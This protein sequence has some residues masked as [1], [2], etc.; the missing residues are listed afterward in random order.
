MLA[1]NTPLSGLSIVVT[2]GVTDFTFNTAL[3]NLIAGT[4]T[5]HG[6]MAHIA[7]VLA[8]YIFDRCAATA[9]IT[10][11]PVLL[12]IDLSLGTPQ[13]NNVQPG[14][15]LTLPILHIGALGG[16]A[17]GVG[18]V[19][20]KSFQLN[21]STNGWGSLWAF[22]DVGE[23]RLCNA[24][25]GEV[26]A[27]VLN[28]TCRFQP[29]Y[30]ASF[31]CSFVDSGNY[32]VLSGA[33]GDDHAD[34]VATYA[35]FGAATIARDLSLRAQQRNL[36]GP[37]FK[38]GIFSSFGA[39]RN[40]LNLLSIN[41]ARLNGMTGTYKRTDQLTAGQYLR[42]GKLL[43]CARYKSSVGDSFVLE[44]TF[45]TTYVPS[46]GM[47]IFAVSEAEALTCE[48]RRTGFLIPYEPIDSSGQTSWIGDAYVPR[49]SGEWKVAPEKAARTPLYTYDFNGLLCTAPGFATP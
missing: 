13:P 3:P 41:E 26:S 21:N 7:T 37:G 14:V 27:G 43:F 28:A 2:D 25:S 12:N 48:W 36:T 24:A 38:V 39:T 23:T 8:Q 42:I 18:P 4:Y 45:P 30:L 10:V 22:C 31:R 19:T 40:I 17:T 47:P 46:S 44:E 15:N 9:G 33:F 20:I 6:W 5:P 1:S 34:G 16:A 49:F 11:K 29:R 32:E 35:E